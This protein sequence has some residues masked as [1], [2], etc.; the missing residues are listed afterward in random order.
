[1]SIG[2]LLAA[3]AGPAAPPVDGEPGPAVDLSPWRLQ[4]GGVRT[5]PVSQ[6]PLRSELRAA[7]TL[8]SDDT[9]IV[10]VRVPVAGT[11]V[12]VLG[13]TV[14]Q[15]VRRGEPL[16]VLEAADGARTR[17]TAPAT[18]HISW[19]LGSAGSE[20]AADQSVCTIAD[21]SRI[22][23]WV[24]V[25]ES[26]LDHVHLGQAAAVQV[27]AYPGDT[28]DGTVTQLAPL[29]DPVTHTL[30]ARVD[31]RNADF[32]LKPGMSGIVR[33]QV[34]L[35]ERLAVPESAVIRAG[36]RDRVYVDLGQGRFEPRE[37]VLGVRAGEWI[38][39]RSG[40]TPG[41]S[42]V[43]AANFLVDAEARLGGLR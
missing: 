20:V 25:F 13:N 16:L 29:L 36:E 9:R 43:T 15:Q 10:E 26:D 12:E 17:V 14:G 37:V 42:I 11:I 5:T 39:V 28:F 23:V 8:A 35:G 18:G 27:P 4:L 1:M 40:L 3:C 6:V 24:Q 41:E 22:W 30:R 31:L 19:R 21:H 32:R 7:G 38:E 2:V 33:L 34:E